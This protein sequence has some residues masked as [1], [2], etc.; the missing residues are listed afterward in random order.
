LA[1]GRASNNVGL[2]HR[3]HAMAPLNKAYD[4]RF[5]P[6]IPLRPA[7]D[8]L[9]AG[10]PFPEFLRRIVVPERDPATLR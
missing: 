6:S 8:P 1:I 3:A 5:N 4:A 10:P 9:R 7:F 2:G